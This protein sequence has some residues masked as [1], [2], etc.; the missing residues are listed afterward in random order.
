MTDSPSDD[1]PALGRRPGLFHRVLMRLEAKRRLEE[2]DGGKC[3]S[4]RPK[5]FCTHGIVKNKIE[6]FSSRFSIF[7][8]SMSSDCAL[9]HAGV[10]QETKSW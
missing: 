6:C 1:V 8:D 7:Y 10:L 9:S 2:T 4:R 5:Y 3:R